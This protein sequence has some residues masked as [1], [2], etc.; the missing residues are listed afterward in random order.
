[1]GNRQTSGGPQPFE[2]VPP[3]LRYHKSPPQHQRVPCSVTWEW[4]DVVVYVELGLDGFAVRH[5]AA[6]ANGN[7]LR[8]DRHHWVDEFGMLADARYSRKRWGNSWGEPVPIDAGE[9]ERMWELA[10]HA[11]IHQQQLNYVRPAEFG[12]EPP[13][14]MI[15]RQTDDRTG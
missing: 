9:F 6:Y 5:V 14:I 2:P 1:V 3:E 7:L 15:A 10:G 13:W 8:Y 11:P 12:D 4:G